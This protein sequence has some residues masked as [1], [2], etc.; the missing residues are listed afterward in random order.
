[1]TDRFQEALKRKLAV[2]RDDVVAKI[3]ESERLLTGEPKSFLVTFRIKAA[4]VPGKGTY[5]ERRNALLKRIEALAGAKWHLST[6]VWKV[7][8]R[9]TSA[10]LLTLLSVPLEKRVDF[11]SVTAV[12]TTRTFGDARLED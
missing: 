9:R 10:T 1:M 3:Q 4:D 8:S 12:G 5:D 2:P 11:L 6:S 7:R